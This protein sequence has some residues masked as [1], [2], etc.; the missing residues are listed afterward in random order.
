MTG[1]THDGMRN[2]S[3]PPARHGITCA[4]CGAFT[5]TAIEELFSNPRVGAP[6]RFCDPA[7]RAAA[8]RRRQAG[9]HENTPPTAHR[10]SITPPAPRCPTTRN[11]TVHQQGGSMKPPSRL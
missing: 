1:T 6:Q 8:W 4:S 5:L 11:L 2:A 7:C 9:V 10:R 3:D